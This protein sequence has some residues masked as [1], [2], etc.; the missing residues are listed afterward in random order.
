MNA[1]RNTPAF[2]L[3]LASVLPPSPIPIPFPCPFPLCLSPSLRS[4]SLI[5]LVPDSPSPPLPPSPLCL[6][7]RL[8]PLLSLCLH[9]P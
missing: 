7:V 6:S 4:P 5:H 3:P 1:P 9:V 8:A 2:P